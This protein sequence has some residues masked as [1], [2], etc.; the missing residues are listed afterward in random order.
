LGDVK[1]KGL[2]E[3]GKTRARAASAAE[4]V[5]RAEAARVLDVA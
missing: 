4:T 3:W 5:T 1:I 2:R